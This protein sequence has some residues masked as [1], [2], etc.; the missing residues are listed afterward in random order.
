MSSA[1]YSSTFAIVPA[2]IVYW[3]STAVSIE[4]NPSIA[5]SSFDIGDVGLFIDHITIND[6]LRH[7]THNAEENLHQGNTTPFLCF[8]LT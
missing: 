4:Y 6:I 2:D 1:N 8:L 7:V 3:R 5:V